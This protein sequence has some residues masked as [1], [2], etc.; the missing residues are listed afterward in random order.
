LD[1]KIE[2]TCSL[3]LDRV[4]KHLNE[5]VKHQME[6]DHTETE[7]DLRRYDDD[8]EKLIIEEFGQCLAEIIE[9]AEKRNLT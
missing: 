9:T 1:E 6:E 4:S 3:L 2:Y 7:V 5:L 8:A